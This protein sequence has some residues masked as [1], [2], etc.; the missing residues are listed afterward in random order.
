MAHMGHPGRP[1]RKKQ[2]H[3]EAGGGELRVRGA[4]VVVP[5]ERVIRLVRVKVIPVRALLLFSFRALFVVPL[6]GRRRR[7][8]PQPPQETHR[9]RTC[10]GRRPR[11]RQG[12]LAAGAHLFVQP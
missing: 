2:T 12:L 11:G 9:A 4:A 7:Q 5:V 3:L 6:S 8:H 1:T 10:A